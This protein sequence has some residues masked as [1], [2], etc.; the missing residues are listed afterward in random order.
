MLDLADDLTSSTD[1]EPDN[2]QNGD[3]RSQ[4]QREWHTFMYRDVLGVGNIGQNSVSD[5]AD[6]VSTSENKVVGDV[7]MTDLDGADESDKRQ[8]EVVIVERP[9]WDIEQPPRFDGGQDWE[10]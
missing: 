2:E 6:E 3:E 4:A 10:S 8:M 7:D 9:I 1:E 5:S